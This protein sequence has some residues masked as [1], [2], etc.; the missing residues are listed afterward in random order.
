M[1]TIDKILEMIEE[2]DD[3]IIH[4]HQRADPD[5]YGSQLSLK[6]A[7]KY[8]YPDKNVYAVGSMTDGLDW[9]GQLDEISDDKYK[10]ALVIVTD[11]ANTER[12]DDN[13]WSMGSEVI[14]IDHHPND[15]AYGDIQWVEE[16]AP[17]TSVMIFKMVEASDKMQMNAEIARYM[18]IGIVGDT[19]R[20][21]FSLNAD[22][23]L[24]VSELFKYDFDYQKVHYK[25]QTITETEAKLSGYVLENINIT[26]HGFAWVV[27]TK[28]LLRKYD[29]EFK[30]TNFLVQLPARID[31]VKTWAIF[32]EQDDGRYRVR[33][34]SRSVVVNEVAKKYKG[35]GHPL[36][37]GAW[38]KDTKEI[39]DIIRIFD[40]LLKENNK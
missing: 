13:R 33:L 9:I 14:K 38:A 5:A 29:M 10:K 26:E 22:L 30:G 11:A 20:F 15:D 1:A 4:R 17:A 12:I 37:S 40:N 35:G 8:A 24:V 34:R 16:D 19:G 6:A 2:Y 7:I 3:I 21:N 23:F 32:A 27:V 28:K 36:A 25:M 18:Y 39:D 31:K